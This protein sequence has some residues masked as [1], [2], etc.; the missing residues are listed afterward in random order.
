MTYILIGFGHVRLCRHGENA[1]FMA[2]L[3]EKYIYIYIYI[4]IYTHIYT[5]DNMMKYSHISWLVRDTI[6]N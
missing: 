6:H 5:Y 2:C 3:I 1:S 4:Y